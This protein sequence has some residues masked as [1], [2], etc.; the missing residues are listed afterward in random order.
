[1]NINE[2][3][4]VLKDI[5]WRA[6]EINQGEIFYVK[7]KISKDS[8][9]LII[10]DLI[11]VWWRYSNPEQTELDQSKYNSHLDSPTENTLNRLK[12][13][14]SEKNLDTIYKSTIQSN[15]YLQIIISTKISFYTFKWVFELEPIEKDTILRVESRKSHSIFI[16]DNFIMPLM[17]V[18][19]QLQL[20]SDLLSEQKLYL[21]SIVNDQ[22]SNSPQI[23]NNSNTKQSTTTPA[24]LS[25]SSSS[26]QAS[27]LRNSST[28]TLPTST[29]LAITTVQKNSEK[30]PRNHNILGKKLY[31]PILQQ[32]LDFPMDFDKTDQFNL[33][34]QIFEQYYNHKYNITDKKQS[35]ND[36]DDD[37]ENSDLNTTI[38]YDYDDNNNNDKNDKDEEHK[39]KQNSLFS[40]KS[41]PTTL[42]LKYK[43]TPQK[44]KPTLVYQS[45]I[46]DEKNINNNNS[47]LSM[48]GSSISLSQDKLN[49][50][51]TQLDL[52]SNAIEI[53]IK[54]RSEIKEKMEEKKLKSKKKKIK[55]V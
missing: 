1:M 13:K 50:Q 54:R 53:E 27:E 31:H 45:T 18:Q 26:S 9:Y 10:T 44:S 33:K 55:F 3:S 40:L 39:N 52:N 4:N 30:R 32:S 43:G 8:Y 23:N 49:S 22:N 2:C 6:L 29:S 12:E 20:K 48:S 51:D 38:D 25:S 17:F 15:F 35:N 28:L 24:S 5:E 42:S 34:N 47:I 19:K 36:D 37:D 41:E 7:F 14:L 46:L 11:M 16:R 21:E